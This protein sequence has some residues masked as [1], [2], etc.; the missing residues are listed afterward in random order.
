M[1]K[2]LAA[3]TVT[4]YTLDLQRLRRW[5]NRSVCRCCN[6]RPHIRRRCGAD[7]CGQAQRRGMRSS[8]RAGAAFYLWAA[9]QGLTAHNPVQGVRAPRPQ[10]LPKALGVD[11]AVRLAD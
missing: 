10:A 4:L 1:E 2:R 7:A 8:S 9:R 11:D 5:A 3:R 6:C